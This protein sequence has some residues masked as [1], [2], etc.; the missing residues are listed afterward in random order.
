M[1]GSLLA[2]ALLFALGAAAQNKIQVKLAPE[3]KGPY[4]GRLIVYTQADTT[5]GFTGPEEPGY[6]IEVKNWKAGE[7]QT[8]TAKAATFLKSLDS[9]KGHFKFV[10]ILDT[11]TKERGTSAPGNL[12]TRKEDVFELGNGSSPAVLTLTHVFKDRVFNQSDSVK[13]V[14]FKT[15]LVSQFRKEPIYLKAGVVL[16]PSY[17]KEPNRVYPVVYVI[18]GWGGTHHNA[19]SQGHRNAYGVG[20]GEEKI[21]VFLNPDTHDPFGLH[22]VIDSR[23][24][25]PWGSALVKELMPYM[26]KNYRASADPKLSFLTGQSTGGYAVIWLALHFPKHFGGSWST[27]PDP[28]DFSNFLGVNI[29]KDK[30]FYQ[31]NSGKDREIYLIKGVNQTTLRKMVQ[32]ELLDGDGGQH[33]AFEA[34]FGEMGKDNRPVQLF[35]GKTGII[36]RKVAESWKPYDLALY[37]QQNW[38]GLKDKVGSKIRIYVGEDDNFMLQHSVR[39]FSERIKTVNATIYT[40][41]IKGA[42]HFNT[43]GLVAKRVQEEMDALIKQEKLQQ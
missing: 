37:V 16:P 35:D 39:A 13:E 42:D 19:N 33:Q 7:V 23:V 9:L 15:V 11:N 43:R 26:V 29:Y 28:V 4:T 24:N 17:H 8:I 31:D 5:K 38:P 32:K 34:E 21:F 2:I 22:A 30:N 36:N 40:E 14:V 1:R 27:A 3:L 10:A 25:G 20:K 41:F 12:Y 18:P 6:A